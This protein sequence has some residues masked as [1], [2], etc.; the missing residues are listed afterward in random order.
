LRDFDGKIV[1]VTGEILVAPDA[2]AIA[3]LCAQ[4]SVNPRN[5][6]P[7]LQLDLSFDL[8][9][10]AKRQVTEARQG[11]GEAIARGTYIRATAEIEGLVEVRR[12]PLAGYSPDGTFPG[13]ILVTRIRNLEWQVQPPGRSLPVITVCDLFRD[14]P[15]YRGKRIAVRGQLAGTGEGSWLVAERVYPYKF[16]TDGFVWGHDL[17]LGGWP[18][19]FASEFRR[20]TSPLSW[21]PRDRPLGPMGLTRPATIVT[22]VGVLN[23][24][25]KYT[26]VCRFGEQR[27]FG[28]GHLSASPASLSVEEIFDAAV[29]DLVPTH[30]TPRQ[31]CSATPE[32]PQK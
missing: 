31:T 6:P 8:E 17:A 25:D 15:S 22:L 23:V 7:A 26:V 27:S 3:G 21:P 1:V 10:T 11:A 14:L 28:F 9:E 19:V 20:E 4:D 32:N 24:R 29:E 30:G 2:L 12:Q 18:N 5:W 13:R 16:E